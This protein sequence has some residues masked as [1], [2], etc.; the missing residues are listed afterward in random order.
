MPSR[1]VKA[2]LAVE[3]GVDAEEV[4]DSLPADADF[5]IVGVTSGAEETLGWLRTGSAD[6][7]LVACA[8]YSDRALLLLDAVGRQSPDMN[9]MVLGQGSP[10]GF[11]RRAFEA[12][13]DDI[14]MLPATRDQVR[15]EI[16]KLLARKQGEDV[17]SAGDQ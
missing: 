11:L 7:L 2:L 14:V 3:P 10:N 13:A 4:R 1:A 8:G 6:L 17:P 12:G 15:F 16:H 9:V 5:S